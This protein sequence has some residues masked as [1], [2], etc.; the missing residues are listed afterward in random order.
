MTDY[1]DPHNLIFSHYHSNGAVGGAQGEGFIEFAQKN[2]NNQIEAAIVETDPDIRQNMYESIQKLAYEHALGIP[3]Y[4]PID[5]FL[6][7]K[8]VKG[9]EFN[10]MQCGEANYDEIYKEE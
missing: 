5:I 3:L 1:P 7:K 10:P 8:W 9:W 6:M 4:Q 2:L